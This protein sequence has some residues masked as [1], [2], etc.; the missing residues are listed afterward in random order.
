MKKII[1]GTIAAAT[2]VASMTAASAQNRTDR[3][4]HEMRTH[5]SME[6]SWETPSRR[7]GVSYGNNIRFERS[8]SVN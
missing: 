8:D 5:S 6:Q 1:F 3:N 4:W 2:V 7:K